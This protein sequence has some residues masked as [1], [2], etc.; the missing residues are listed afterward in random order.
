MSTT[1]LRMFSAMSDAQLE[2]L[3]DS[4]CVSVHWARR[5]GAATMAA[6]LQAAEHVAWHTLCVRRGRRCLQ[7]AA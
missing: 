1:L 6:D 2:D 7:D 4:L 3:T 5:T